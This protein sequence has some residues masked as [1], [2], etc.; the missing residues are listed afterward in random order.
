MHAIRCLLA[1]AVL[2]IVATATP[3]RAASYSTDQSDLWWIPAES[4]WGIQ[5]V[6]RNSTI[7]ATMFIYDSAG[8]ATWYVATMGASGWIW[9][10]DLYSTRGPWFGAV[11]FAS[12]DV[13]VTKVGTMTWSS[14]DAYSGTLTYSVNGVQVS[15][16]LQRQFIAVD[17]FSGDYFGVL[18]KDNTGCSDPTQ[19]GTI[20]NPLG[21][22]IVQS[23][24]TVNFMTVDVNLNVCTYAGSV[25]QAGQMGSMSATF[26]CS[27][28]S[29]GSAT[30][31]ELQVNPSGITGRI[32][33]QG[34]PSGC[35]STGWFGAGRGTTF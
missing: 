2:A 21:V 33:A 31:S 28:G 32:A 4:G 15:K 25:A 7:F 5:F 17:D 3:A 35:A 10:G 16:Q 20:E 1:A 23:G 11:P 29:H 27:D 34:A 22:A 9:T 26:T 19:N 8:A 14:S 12:A 6:Q 13:Q 18:H 24:S 30:L